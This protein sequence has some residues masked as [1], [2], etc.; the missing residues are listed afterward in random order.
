MN[1]PEWYFLRLTHSATLNLTI[2]PL[3]DSCHILRLGLRL[4]PIMFIGFLC[5]NQSI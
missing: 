2:S 3:C 4:S 5:E 1:G